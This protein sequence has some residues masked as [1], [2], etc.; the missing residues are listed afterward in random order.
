VAVVVN[1]ANQ[2]Y[3]PS[4]TVQQA[5]GVYT[6]VDNRYQTLNVTWTTPPAVGDCF[7]IAGV[8]SVHH[9]TKQDTGHLKTFRVTAVGTNTITITPPIIS[10]QGGS[11]P[12]EQYQNVTATPANGAALT[13]LNTAN[14]FANPFWEGEA[15]EIVPGRL[16][17]PE[18]AGVATMRGTTDDGIELVMSKQVGIGTL[19]VNY[20]FDCYY[21]VACKQPEMAGIILFGQ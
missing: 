3:V 7:T 19:A 20:R 2:Y 11:R 5:D 18:N 8:D 16:V 4:A 15:M 6:N 13:F 12:E 17:V 1:G 10:A 14:A 21:G 9:I